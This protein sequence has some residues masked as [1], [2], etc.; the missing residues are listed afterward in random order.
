M[1]Y[2]VKR[3][4]VVNL[5][6]I[7]AFALWA[8]PLFNSMCL[9]SDEK[10]EAEFADD[11]KKT[12]VIGRI[13]RLEAEGK[14]FLGLYTETERTVSKS[15]VIILHDLGG[16]PN[17]RQ[18]VDT[19]RVFLPE[20][21]W[22]TLALQM[23]VREIGADKNDYYGLLPETRARIQAGIKYAKDNRAENIVLIGYGLGSLMALYAQSEQSS[24]IK[25][26]V[27]ISLP[28]PDANIKTVKVLEYI[29]KIKIPMLDIYGALDT[30]DVV[31]SARDRRLAAKENPGYRQIKI[32]DEDRRYLHDEGLVVKR[33]YSWL[34]QVS[35][36]SS[37]FK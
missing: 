28:V 5:L 13:V 30:A 22:A 11:I 20:H 19:L 34:S 32:T 3:S 4:A 21:D 15:V 33:I 2:K 29:K 35:G 1:I 6:K 27:T 14:N 8:L 23:P 17:Q 25:A 12:L 16:H 7:V 10:R 37:G 9:A 24:A 36:N 26:L 18:V 31:D